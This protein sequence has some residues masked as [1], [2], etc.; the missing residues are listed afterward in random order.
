LFNAGLRWGVVGVAAAW[1]LSSWIL[2]VPAFSY[3]GQPIG[4][5]GSSIIQTVWKYI[6]A[7]LASG[8]TAALIVGQLPILAALGGVQGAFIRLAIKLLL[9]GSLYVAAVILLHG[10]L[11]PVANFMRLVMQMVPFAKQSSSGVDDECGVAQIP[12]M[13]LTNDVN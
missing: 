4:L 10:S 12:P 3:A 8:A 13:A 11:T 2:T 9:V 5:K 1:T 6:I 7:S